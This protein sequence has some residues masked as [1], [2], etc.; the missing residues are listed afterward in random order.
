[1]NSNDLTASFDWMEFTILDTELE[2]ITNQILGI[3]LN[4]FTA[5]NRGK[6]GYSQQLKWDAGNLYILYNTNDDGNPIAND[7]MGVHVLLSGTGCRAY[8]ARH[9]LHRLLVVIVALGDSAKFSRI[10][11]AIDDKADEILNFTR[12]RKAAVNQ[13]FTSRWSKW[14]EVVSRRC[15]NGEILGRTMYFGSQSSDIFCRIYDKALEQSNK[16]KNDDSKVIPDKWTRL[17]IIYRKE[18]AKLLAY[19]LVDNPKV[20]IAIRATLT[21]YIRFVSKPRKSGDT[22]KSRWPSAMWWDKFLNDV[23]ALV[24]TTKKSEKTIADMANWID[25][26]IA[27]TLATIIK[28]SEGDLSWLYKVIGSGASR[29]KNKHHQAIAQYLEMKEKEAA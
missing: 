5:L 23:Q 4:D 2:V 20:G 21:Q 8:E 18:R 26:Q 11:L 25:K 24:L 17:E 6:F 15:G 19:H 28:A 10:D 7:R 16:Y 1:M 9:S 27:P 3:N 13:M 22:N 29:M 14:D 12:I